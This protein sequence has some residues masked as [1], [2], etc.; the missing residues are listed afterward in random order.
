[1]FHSLLKLSLIGLICLPLLNQSLNIE[2]QVIAENNNRQIILHHSSTTESEA[3]L[4]IKNL[5]FKISSISLPCPDDNCIIDFEIQNKKDLTDAEIE[6]IIS[7]QD[8]F[9]KTIVKIPYNLWQ[10]LNK[11]IF[12]FDKNIVRGAAN[13]NQ[14]RLRIVNITDEEFTAVLIHELGH[15]ADLGS[16]QG[17]TDSTKSNFPDGKIATY[18]NDPSVKF[19]AAYWT[20]SRQ[21]KDTDSDQQNFISGYSRTDCFEHFAETFLTYVL[22]SDM[23]K[24]KNPDQYNYFKDNVFNRFEYANFSKINESD[25][26]H[27]FYDSTKQPYNFE[28]FLE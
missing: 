10:P 5:E 8:L 27:Y 2:P 16:L 14:I 3:Q 1:M 12:S 18:A 22:H 17:D 26:N 13:G 7:Y 23:L 25:F 21:I 24:Y 15:I 19:Y 11:V 4:K 9:Q 20:N 28:G 6:T